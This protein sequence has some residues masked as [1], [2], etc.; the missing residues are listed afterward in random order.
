MVRRLLNARADVN[1]RSDN[2]CA[3]VHA[4]VTDG[5][6][7]IVQLLLEAKAD[8]TLP[9]GQ[10]LSP[11]DYAKQEEHYHVVAVLRD[12]GRSDAS[13]VLSLRVEAP[14][15][16]KHTV[17]VPLTATVGDLFTLLESL[18]GL[19]NLEV[20]HKSGLTQRSLNEKSSIQ[21]R[22]VE[23]CHVADRDVL[24]LTPQDTEPNPTS[25][26]VPLVRRVSPC[27]HRGGW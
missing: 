11:M 8:H 21:C 23:D 1:S 13:E 16:Q 24:L 17:R 3:P 5:H 9:D 7:S 20:I 27:R 22:L 4:A 25:L 26:D 10:G 15:Y 18:T 12:W 2:G 14:Q 6:S 19:S